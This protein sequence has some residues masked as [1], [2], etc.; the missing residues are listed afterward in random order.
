MYAFNAYNGSGRNA[1]IAPASDGGLL[2]QGIVEDKGV[3][4]NLSEWPNSKVTVN[5]CSGSR[6]HFYGACGDLVLVRCQNI[7]VLSDGVSSSISIADCEHTNMAI[8]GNVPPVSVHRS[9]HCSLMAALDMLREPVETH[10]CTAIT[11]HAL[12]EAVPNITAE[13]GFPPLMPRSLP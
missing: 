6:I 11:L 2:V 9:K 7:V 5:E 13:Y 1:I 10:T 12:H 3:Q 4:I 8:G